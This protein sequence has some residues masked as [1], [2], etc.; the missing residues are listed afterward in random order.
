MESF[1]TWGA[2]A[3]FGGAAAMTAL[4]TQLTKNIGFVKKIPTQLWSYVIAL[5]VLFPATGFTVGL[6]WSG[7]LL[8]LFNAISV[9]L[10]ANGIFS[11]AERIIGSAGRGGGTKS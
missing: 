2:L 8:I 4:I 10:S 7:A 6:N 3:S 5:A 11:A 9:S 1:V